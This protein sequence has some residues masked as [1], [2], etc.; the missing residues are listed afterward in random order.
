MRSSRRLAFVAGVCLVALWLV[1]LATAKIWFM[2]VRG[3]TFTAG[4]VIV[5]EI[6]GCPVPCP[7]AGVRV[8]LAPGARGAVLPPNPR[9]LGTVTR[10]GALRFRV[11]HVAPG[12][13]H[14]VARFQKRSLPASDGFRIIH[15]G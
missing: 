8:Y 4:K 15:A 10:S 11:P 7:I 5:T 2:S 1:P 14:L 3:K 6:A 12:S 13:Y 9:L